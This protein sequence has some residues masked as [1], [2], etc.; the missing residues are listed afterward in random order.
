MNSY[1][2]QVTRPYG[3]RQQIAG[4]FYVAAESIEKARRLGREYVSHKHNIKRY[5]LRVI[6]IT[7]NDDYTE[8]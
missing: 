8:V 6:S 7:E 1:W 2:F 5:A 4:D 3:S